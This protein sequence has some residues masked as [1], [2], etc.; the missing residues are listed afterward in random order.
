MMD[1]DDLGVVL[2][3]VDALFCSVADGIAGSTGMEAAHRNMDAVRG[4]LFQVGRY[5]R[6]PWHRALP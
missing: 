1:A 6:Q 3:T 2:E 4:G 5:R